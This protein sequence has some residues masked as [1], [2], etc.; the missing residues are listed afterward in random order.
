MGV[1]GR[2]G[3][4]RPDTIS[5]TKK[6]VLV[7]TNDSTVFLKPDSFVSAFE[8]FGGR[9]TEVKTLFTRISAITNASMGIISGKFGFIPSNYVVMKYD[10]VPSCKEEYEKLQ[11]EKDFV[12]KIE[13]LSKPFDKIVVCVPKDMFAMLLPVLPNDKVIAVTNK[14]YKDECKNRG[15]SFYLRKG[16]RVGDNNADAIVKEI[17]ELIR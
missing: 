14:I 9:C 5:G 12:G 4:M 15:W 1:A 17:E 3:L 10:F 6:N 7:I 11:Q 16:A 8:M 13:T 2:G